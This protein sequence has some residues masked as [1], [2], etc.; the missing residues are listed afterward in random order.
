MISI[1]KRSVSLMLALSLTSCAAIPESSSSKTDSS[2]QTALSSSEQSESS[3][4]SS[5][6]TTIQTT[7]A[8]T[9]TTTD[10]TTTTS[11]ETTITEI[12]TTTTSV[13][14]APADSD[15]GDMTVKTT[16]APKDD[17]YT[18]YGG[19]IVAHSGTKDARAMEQYYYSQDTAMMLAGNVNIF[20][21]KAGEDTNVYLM[22]IPSA[23]ELYNP[24]E[25]QQNTQDQTDCT[26]E[27]YSNLSGAVGVLV[28]V[29]L[30]KHKD[31]YLYS[32]TDFHWQP[33]AAYYA[34]KKFSEEAGTDFPLLDTYKMKTREG[35]LG[36]FYTVSGISEFESCPDDFTYF[37]PANMDKLKVTCY[38]RSF[39]NGYETN[40]I[41]EDF[42]VDNSYMMFGSDDSIIEVDTDV[43][44]DRVLVIFKD[45]YGNALTPFLT[46]SFSKIYVCDD[47]FFDL[48]S[49]D[50]IKKVKA[51]DVLFAFGIATSG[52]PDKISLIESL[53][54]R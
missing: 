33:L 1:I 21:K 25:L 9:T 5:T 46:Q 42:S 47:R 52:S 45:S 32:R 27:I 8:D 16:K 43:K 34:A 23:Q 49:I 18:Y 6:T 53:M 11:A 4:D 29:I 44:N 20:K 14:A 48:N 19:V 13:T 54:N 12:E 28:N 15:T 39:S 40:L 41:H 26:L 7:A 31:E 2:Q 51:T 36:G 37:C 35:F 50:F 17:S 38:D 24:T 30:K 22:V 10:E 3:S